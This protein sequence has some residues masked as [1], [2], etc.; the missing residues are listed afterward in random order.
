MSYGQSRVYG[1]SLSYLRQNGDRIFSY[2]EIHANSEYEAIQYVRGQW[3]RDHLFASY[4]PDVSA[5]LLCVD[6]WRT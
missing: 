4:E 1:V 6:Y 2:Y 5:Q 3:H